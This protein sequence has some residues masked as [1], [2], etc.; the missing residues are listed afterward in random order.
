MQLSKIIYTILS[1]LNFS[2]WSV[3]RA[4]RC[5]SLEKKRK[6]K[7]RKIIE[8]IE[9]FAMRLITIDAVNGYTIIIF[10]LSFR[11]YAAL[12]YYANQ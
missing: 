5:S 1:K 2:S 11:V 3:N 9:R 7:K 6:E 12:K 8:S 4:T 10:K